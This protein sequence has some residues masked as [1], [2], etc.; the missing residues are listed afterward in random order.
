MYLQLALLCQASD[1]AGFSFAQLLQAGRD[2]VHVEINSAA[3]LGPC[4]PL[5]IGIQVHRQLFL[6]VSLFYFIFFVVC[7]T[8]WYIIG[9]IVHDAGSGLV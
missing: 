3:V 1:I 4:I 5:L 9:I 8:Y 7:G 6:W 2:Q